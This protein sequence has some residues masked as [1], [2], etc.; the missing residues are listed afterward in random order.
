MS[1]LGNGSMTATPISRGR[2]RALACMSLCAVLA[3]VSPAQTA[4]AQHGGGGGG[5]GGGGH[6]GG[7]GGGHGGGGGAATTMTSPASI[8][9]SS[10][11]AIRP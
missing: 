3:A 8:S 6:G 11:G 4:W 2:R 9:A 10:A 5:H 7:G 1:A